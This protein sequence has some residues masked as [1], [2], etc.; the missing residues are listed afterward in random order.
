MLTVRADG[1]RMSTGW[2]GAWVQSHLDPKTSAVLDDT[3]HHLAYV[4]TGHVDADGRPEIIHYRD[5]EV[6][7][8]RSPPPAH[9]VN[10]DGLARNSWALTIGTQLFTNPQRP[11]FIGAIDELYIVRRALRPGQIR[12]LY[13]Q[14]RMDAVTA[15]PP[16]DTKPANGTNPDQ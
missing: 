16:A 5:G 9:P 11:T 3:W 2:G 6:A 7:P 14:N 8:L 12:M 1:R 15:A 13:E 4:F 10:T